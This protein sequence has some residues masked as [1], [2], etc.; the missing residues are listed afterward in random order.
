VRTL[1][2]DA[3]RE[4]WLIGKQRSYVVRRSDLDRYIESRRVRPLAG[5]DD[6][7]LDRRVARIADARAA[8]KAKSA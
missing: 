3:R 1:T 7:D 8:K 2:T 6:A 5:A 4:G